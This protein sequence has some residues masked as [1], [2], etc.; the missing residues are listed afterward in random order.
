MKSLID[1]WKYVAG[2]KYTRLIFIGPMIA[3]LF[4]G[5]MFSQNQL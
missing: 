3:A 5:L 4:F 1:E 2:S